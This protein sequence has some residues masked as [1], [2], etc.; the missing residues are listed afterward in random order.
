MLDASSYYSTY[1]AN[2]RQA[3]QNRLSKRAQ[4][5]QAKQA[6]TN[7][8]LTAVS[9]A[10]SQRS[11]QLEAGKPNITLNQP[12]PAPDYLPLVLLA[13]G[14]LVLIFSLVRRG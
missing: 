11:A 2:D 7:Q 1:S 13:A 6:A 8:L 14:A 10:I 9:L 5:Q 4:K 3:D 12:A